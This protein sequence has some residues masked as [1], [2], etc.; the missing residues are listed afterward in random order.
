[1]DPELTDHDVAYVRSAFR[2]QTEDERARAAAGLA[3][4]PSYILPDGTPMTSAELDQDLAEAADAEDLH[5]RFVSRWVDAGGNARDADPELAAWL[6]GGY[7]ACLRSPAPEAILAKDGLARAIEALTARP[8]PHL[9]WWRETLG[10]AVDAYDSLVLP[11]ASV[12]PVR[13]G[14]T[15][16]RARLVD[17]VR[18]QWPELFT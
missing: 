12:D 7:G 6:R 15:T 8:L 18:A 16:S 14:G 2:P 3:A 10:Y 9:T 5:R 17:S 13:F 11:F 4:E 1:M